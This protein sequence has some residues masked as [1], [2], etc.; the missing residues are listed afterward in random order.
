MGCGCS[1]QLVAD[2]STPEF[3]QN[4]TANT[5]QVEDTLG[6]P[7]DQT[8]NEF[9]AVANPDGSVASRHSSESVDYSS[10]LSFNFQQHRGGPRSRYFRLRCL[11]HW[12]ELAEFV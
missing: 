6:A 3:S 11:L 9:T 2:V 7:V 4:T 1:K 12:I 5:G 10:E 8:K